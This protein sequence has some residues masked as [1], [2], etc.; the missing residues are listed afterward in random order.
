MSIEKS[1]HSN[2][3]WPESSWQLMGVS[4]LLYHPWDVYKRMV[5]RS[6]DKEIKKDLVGMW[7]G[8]WEITFKLL[9]LS[10]QWENNSV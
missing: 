8:E 10:H 2:Q 4:K 7:H 3:S 5:P 1:V 6:Q 9:K